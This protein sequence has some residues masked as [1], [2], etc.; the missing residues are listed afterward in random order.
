MVLLWWSLISFPFG[1]NWQIVLGGALR[2]AL[3]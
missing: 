1:N 3:V 2:H